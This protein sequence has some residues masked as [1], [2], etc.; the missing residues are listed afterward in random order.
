MTRLESVGMISCGGEGSDG[1]MTTKI[2]T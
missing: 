2:P 1:V